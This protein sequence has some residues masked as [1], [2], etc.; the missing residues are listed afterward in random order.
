LEHRLSIPDEASAHRYRLILSVYPFDSEEWLPVLNEEGQVTGDI[1][2]LTLIPGG[3][4]VADGVLS[5][6]CPDHPARVA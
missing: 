1:V 6:L 5:S 2:I 4:T 3:G